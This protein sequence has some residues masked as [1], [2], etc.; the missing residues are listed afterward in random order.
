MEHVPGR[1][2][3][4]PL[5]PGMSREERR[6]I[7]LAMSDVLVQIHKVNVKEAGLDDYGKQGKWVEE[8]G[9]DE[10]RYNM[11]IVEKYVNSDI[12]SIFDYFL[13][14]LYAYNM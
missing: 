11:E 10:L 5:L 8:E 4:D 12:I 3:K 1:V 6:D 13:C 2:F 14:S 7:Y 9:L